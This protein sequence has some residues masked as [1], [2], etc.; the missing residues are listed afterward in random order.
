VDKL[1]KKCMENGQK[2]KMCNPVQDVE[3][4]SGKVRV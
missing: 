3:Q 4:G 1:L 2:E